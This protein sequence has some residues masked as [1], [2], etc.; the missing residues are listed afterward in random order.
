[1]SDWP[2]LHICSSEAISL[3]TQKT[4]FSVAFEWSIISAQYLNRG[5]RVRLAH[6]ALGE[7]GQRRNQTGV[8]RH[9]AADRALDARL[10]LE[11]GEELGG[12]ATTRI[13][14][15]LFVAL[16]EPAVDTYTHTHTKY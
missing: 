6:K 16:G 8:A 11:E 15:A 14:F 10:L 7:I 3:R 12:C 1:M 9:S 4:Y 2:P 13:V 5:A